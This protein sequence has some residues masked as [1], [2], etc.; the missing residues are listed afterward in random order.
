MKDEKYSTK[1]KDEQG[2]PCFALV[3]K[4]TGQAMKHSVG[5][6]HPVCLSTYS[7]SVVLYFLILRG[8]CMYWII[9]HVHCPSLEISSNFYGYLA[10]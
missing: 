10:C 8:I 2:F 6:S 5:A 7:C 3:N 4:A 9:G 1:V